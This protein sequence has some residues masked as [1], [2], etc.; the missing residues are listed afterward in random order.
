MGQEL[1]CECI[2][3][4]FQTTALSLQL[5]DYQSTVPNIDLLHKETK[6]SR[7]AYLGLTKEDIYVKLSN[8]TSTLSWRVPRGSD[9]LSGAWANISGSNPDD[10]GEIS[11]IDNIATIRSI[12]NDSLAIVD[13]SNKV[14]FE[15][16]TDDVELRDKWV[17]ILSELLQSWVSNPSNKPK[18]SLISAAGSSDKT[19]YFA[20]REQ[21]LIDKKK[22]AD[23]RKKKY[24]S[25]GMKYTAIAMMNRENES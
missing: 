19:A 1:S 6:F 11:L 16:S 9:S 15:I 10:F 5:T 13:F 17:S 2:T 24:T 23:E 20:M 25:G 21:Q 12:G 14:V 18:I 8:D 4:F 7:K 22:I 3:Q